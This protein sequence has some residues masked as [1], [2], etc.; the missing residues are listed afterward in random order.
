REG[1]AR[2]SLFLRMNEFRPRLLCRRVGLSA[3]ETH[4]LRGERGGRAAHRTAFERDADGEGPEASR[5]RRRI[6]PRPPAARR[7][8]R[9]IGAQAF[10]MQALDS[11]FDQGR[12]ILTTA[13]E[14]HRFY[15]E[16]KG[17]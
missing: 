11:P 14:I 16:A 2:S 7:H 13:G 12:E 9:R 6:E 4:H 15:E 10:G 17:V 5:A 3:E 1:E 8:L